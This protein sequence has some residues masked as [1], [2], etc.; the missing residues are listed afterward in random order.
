MTLRSL[1]RRVQSALAVVALVGVAVLGYFLLIAPK[2][3]SAAAL[4]DRIEQT[5]AQIDD[6]R[7]KARATATPT[8]LDIA[9]VFRTAK[10]MPDKAAIPELIIELNGIASDSGVSF[11]TIAPGPPV[12]GDGYQAVPLTL[13][14][15]GTYFGMSSFLARI[16]QLV[17]LDGGKL[18]ASGRLVTIESV[19][20]AES[21]E[22]FSKVHATVTLNALV[23]GGGVSSSSKPATPSPA[24]SES[25]SSEASASAGV[26]EGA[27]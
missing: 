23:Y 2:R 5:Q 26:S 25:S 16:R 22:R 6:R 19:S 8:P 13:V 11:E 24:P 4:E 1:S 9:E 3:S 7:A 27:S 14:A 10:A 15:D 17:R 12:E 20:L 21:T 18:E